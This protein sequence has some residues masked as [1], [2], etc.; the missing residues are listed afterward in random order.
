M[1]LG[2]LS[3]IEFYFFTS[4]W[5][6]ISVA[7]I[8]ASLVDQAVKNLPAMLDTQISIPGSG[9][10]PEKRNGYSRQYFCLENSM[11]RGA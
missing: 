3:E 10:S 2:G 8:W 9:R 11:D 6:Y 5:V 1:T 7:A 4:K